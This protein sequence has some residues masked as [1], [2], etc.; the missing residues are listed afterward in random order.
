MNQFVFN[1]LRFELLDE[2]IIHIEKGTSAGF[3]DENT[4]FMS[5]KTK[6]NKSEFYVQDNGDYFTLFMNEYYLVFFKRDGLKDLKV[7]D[8]YGSILYNYKKKLNSGDLPSPNDTPAIFAIFDNPRVVLPKDGYSIK[9]FENNEELKIDRKVDDV[10]LLLAKGQATDLRRLYIKLTGSSELVRFKTLG[11][12]NSRYYKYNEESA[13]KMITDHNDHDIP[14]DNMVI[15][16]DWRK[17]N[18]IGIGYEIDTTLF[19]DMG[20]FF[21]FAHKN[22]VEIMFNDHPEPVKGAKDVFSKEEVAFREEKLTD[23][24]KLGLDYWWYD[25]NWSTRLKSIDEDINPETMGDYL[26]TD[27]TKHYFKS[28][29]KNKDIYR[30]PLIMANVNNVLN[31]KF[32]KIFDSASHRYSFQWTG[33]I[34]SSLDSLAKEVSS[35]IKGNSDEI[36][37]FS[38]DIGGHTG[39]PNKEEYIRWMQF[40]TFEPIFRV[41]AT[42]CVIRFREPWNYDEETLDISRKYLNLRYRLLPLIYTKCFDNYQTGEPLFKDLAFNYDGKLAKNNRTEYLLANDILVSPF[43]APEAK[44]LDKSNFVGKVK[45]SY[46]ENTKFE[47]KPVFTT[48]Y[49]GLDLYFEDGKAP[50]EKM[51]SPYDWTAIY[52]F[53]VKLKQDSKLVIASDDGCNVYVDGKCVREDSSSHALAPA[54]IGFFKK[55]EVHDIKVE[56]YQYGGAAQIYLAY[57]P[58]SKSAK[59]VNLPND[60]WVDVFEGKTYIGETKVFKDNKILEEMPLFVR[61]GSIVPLVKEKDRAMKLDYS[62]L[63][64]DLYPSFYNTDHQSLYE[65]DKVTTAYKLGQYRKTYFDMKYDQ[66]SNSINLNVSKAV[67]EYNDKIKERQYILK[68]NL[69]EGFENVSK[70]LL[71]GEEVEFKLKKKDKKLMPFAYGEKSRTF[72]TIVVKVEKDINEDFEVKFILC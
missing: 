9:S 69:I 24:L 33:D 29:S 46:F 36:T 54:D 71:N 59:F 61:E 5:E 62:K 6:L 20:A 19:P 49:N 68:F 55:G 45:A 57:V 26:F 50:S 43:S 11:F 28:V 40:G 23:L 58:A 22:D 4:L 15:D 10:Y 72:D 51:K 60:R 21:K 44:V 34:P 56:L 12:W 2:E 64:L 27:V 3:C 53:R 41:H 63:T 32:I 17:A 52:E 18:D 48:E 7:Y 16:T 42:N 30:R 35:L 37:Y 1:G 66:L 13:K 31:G 65:D 67:G 8:K 14:L 39:N 47:G 25:R 70:V 38:S